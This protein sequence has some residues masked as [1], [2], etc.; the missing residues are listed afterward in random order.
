M[1]IIARFAYNDYA[2]SAADSVDCRKCSGS[3]FIKKPQW[4]KKPLHNE[5]T[6]MG[7]RPQAVTFGF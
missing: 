2:S 1:L 4:W 7:K 5:I 6:A 3:G